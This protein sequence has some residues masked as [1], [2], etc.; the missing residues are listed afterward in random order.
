MPRLS[1]F[2]QRVCHKVPQNISISRGVRGGPA[3]LLHG[4]RNFNPH[5][6]TGFISGVRGVQP[7]TYTS[8]SSDNH[9]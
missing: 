2:I 7:K 8:A 3:D 4:F 6:V 1:K 9:C 5:I